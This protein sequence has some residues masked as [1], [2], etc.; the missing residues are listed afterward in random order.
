MFG[1]KFP[2][3]GASP[4]V[5]SYDAMRTAI[6]ILGMALPITL[7]VWSVLLVDSPFLLD[8]I[9]SYYHTN[10]RDLFVGILCAVALFLFSYHGYDLLDFIAF[11]VAALGALGV[12]F[13]PAFIKS[14]VNPYIH[15]APQVSVYTNAMHYVCAGVFFVTIALVSMF[16]FTKSG[17]QPVI[18]RKRT[19][20]TVYVMCGVVILLC[21]AAMIVLD[22][23]PDASPVFAYDP[24]FWVETVAL[25]AFA[26]SW[27][28]K[29][30]ALLAD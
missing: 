10:M 23:M 20:N 27:L 18:G 21:V 6:G 1:I 11:K 8:S 13:F 26:F 29:G 22:V 9:S 3:P 30:S 25:F 28:V 24:V 5:M 19:R 15:I 17:G 4:V 12:A 14:P 16:L 7:F 2:K